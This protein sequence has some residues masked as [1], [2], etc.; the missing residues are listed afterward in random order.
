MTGMTDDRSVCF[1]TSSYSFHRLFVRLFSC[2]SVC[3][4][5]FLSFS[6]DLHISYFPA[7]SKLEK[8]HLQHTQVHVE[9]TVEATRAQ[10]SC[11]LRPNVISLTTMLMIQYINMSSSNLFLGFV[12]RLASGNSSFSLNFLLFVKLR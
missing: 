11:A 12:E 6:N 3:S 10:G 2:F 8:M 9:S 4:R 5:I 1:L 7:V